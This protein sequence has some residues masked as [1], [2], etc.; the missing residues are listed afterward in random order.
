MYSN[1][2]V[3]IWLLH[4]QEIAM[5]LIPVHFTTYMS[6]MNLLDHLPDKHNHEKIRA[7][8]LALQSL[9]DKPLRQILAW[10]DKQSSAIHTEEL[11]D[12]LH[13]IACFIIIFMFISGY[14]ISTALLEYGGEKLVNVLGYFL[15]L[16][17]IPFVLSLYTLGYL[18]LGRNTSTNNVHSVL[19]LLIKFFNALPFGSREKLQSL[20][21]HQLVLK[22]LSLAYLQYGSIALTAGALTS[23]VFT[24]ITQDIAFGWNTTLQV[25]PELFHLITDTIAIPWQA[26]FPSAV[27]S[28]ELVELS[29][30]YRLG[31]Q[32]NP[33]LITQ[34][35]ALGSWWQ[36]LALSLMVWG[37]F[38]R[39]ILLLLAK[40]NVRLSI[41]KSLLG[42]PNSSILLKQM[43][44]V[45]ITTHGKT[46]KNSDHTAAGYDLSQQA[47]KPMRTVSLIG[48][49]LDHNQLPL[50][51]DVKQITAEQLYHAGGKNTLQEDDLII[52]SI[53]NPTVILVK[54]W[55]PPMRDFLDFISDLY[56]HHHEE[57]T[58]FPIG[59]AQK[60]FRA[61]ESE[62]T[63]WNSKIASLQLPNISIHHD[64]Y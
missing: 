39:I 19:K 8:G 50:I 14:G 56:S 22:S 62:I 29:H 64:T 18:L 10:A 44:E 60:Q 40:K 55:E 16:I 61:K 36:F 32:I 13:Y 54:A 21:K 43:N 35:K 52:K 12:S 57:I 47:L 26:L 51:M 6:T 25:S 11:K 5:P 42:H 7:E 1:G 59:T 20:L 27:P 46:S 9:K 33:V 23:L 30:H 34:A 31:E 53:K 41:E 58:I 28:M 45:Y 48:W 49:N 15:I 3:T 4:S 24:I 63:I 17:F 2:F 37:L 38:P